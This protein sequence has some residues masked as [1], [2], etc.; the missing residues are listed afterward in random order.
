MLTL[1]AAGLRRLYKD[2]ALSFDASPEEAAIFERCYVTA[3][4]RGKDTQGIALLPLSYRLLKSGA[5]RFGAKL[6]ITSPSP[7]VLL[8][9]GGGGVGQVVASTAM[10]AAIERATT[11]GVATAWVRNTNDFGMASNY[12][13]AAL[14]RDFIGL[15]MSNG[16]PL[17]A[18]WGGCNPLFG[19]N[20]MSLAVPAGSEIPIVIDTSSSPISHGKTILAAREGRRVPLGMLVRS[21]GKVTD[22]PRDLVV[23][24]L[25]RDSEQ[26]GAIMSA[27]IKGF[28][29]LLLVELFAGI[30]S[31][32][33]AS[34]DVERN[35]DSRHPST[36]GQFVMAINIGAITDLQGFKQKVDDLIRAV[37]RSRP[38][39]GGE[40]IRLP[41]EQAELESRRR[42][43]QGIPIR[44]EEWEI[45]R[46]LAREQG[47]S[48]DSLNG[49][50]VSD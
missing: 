28:N 36:M 9:D 22:D 26:L 40:E 10:S 44:E 11:V 37:K 32:A 2:F 20:P 47:V 13:M 46:S 49:L 18:A 39:E 23:D 1:P 3:D 8:V 48:P 33:S 14:D 45:V 50:A 31:G 30:M 34:K 17:V 16:V 15:A 35:P 43:V 21:S 27:G 24:V 29:W 25:D 4:L 12:A 19:T 41:G 42:L 38:V 5:A 6:D 7:S